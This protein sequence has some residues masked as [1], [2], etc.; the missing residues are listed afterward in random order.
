[1][2]HYSSFILRLW[3][4][5]NGEWRS[6]VIQHVASRNK[7]RFSTP[8]EMLDFISHHSA[9]S[10]LALPYSLDTGELVGEPQSLDSRTAPDGLDMDRT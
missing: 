4:E 2:G 7:K 8:E 9:D 3:V 5:T 10:E 6:G 1:V